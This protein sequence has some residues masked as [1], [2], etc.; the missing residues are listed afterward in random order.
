MKRIA[1]TIGIFELN[2]KYS[3]DH[4]ARIYFE[5]LR[6]GKK[7][8]CVRCGGFKKITEQKKHPG[9]YWCGDCRKYFT[10]FTNTPLE[11]SKV[12]PRKWIMAAYMLM[13]ARKGV[14]SLQLSKELDV[15]QTTA[16]YILHRLRLAC[17]DGIEALTGAVEV[18]ETYL[19][20]ISHH[21][22]GG[23]I[24]G[25]ELGCFFL[26]VA[27]AVEPGPVGGWS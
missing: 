24:I 16:W 15:T 11:Y 6:W 7:P 9:R 13:T 14:S 22:L 10:A 8:V 21:P 17:G 12:S 20:R 27:F 25:C 1:K 18:D 2:Q 3:T 26:S 4:K 23:W 19:A 5:E